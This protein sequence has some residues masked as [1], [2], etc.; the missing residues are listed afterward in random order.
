VTCWFVLV[1][2]CSE[3]LYLGDQ[4]LAEIPLAVAERWGPVA[5]ELNLAENCLKCVHDLCI[6]LPCLRV[7]GPLLSLSGLRAAVAHGVPLTDTLV[8]GAQVS[9]QPDQVHS[10]GDAS[11]R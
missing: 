5:K 7:Q 9:G 6:V 1:G 10:V 2:A 4:D 11:V 8:R 3:T